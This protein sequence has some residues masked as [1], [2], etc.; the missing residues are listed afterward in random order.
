MN[1]H[2][3]GLLIQKTGTSNK[4]N[5]EFCGV[6]ICGNK[7]ANILTKY[8]SNKYIFK[9]F[10]TDNDYELDEFIINENP[11]V[12]IIN[13]HI[14][15]TSWINFTLIS[16]LKNNY[17]DIKF[18]MIHYDITQKHI[19]NFD[20]M[21]YLKID[22]IISDNKELVIPN[23]LK[24]KIFTV[25]RSIPFLD[26]KEYEDIDVN[27]EEPIIG[28]HGGAFGHKGI[29]KLVL[30]VQEEFDSALIRLHLPPSYYVDPHSIMK[31]IIV[32]NIRKII[33]KKDIK[34]EISSDFLSDYDMI[35]WLQ[36]NSVNCY[37]YDYL[38][39]H[40]LASSP[41][42]AIASKRPI[43]VN[44]STMLKHLHNLEPSIEIEKTTLKEIIKNGTTPLE[45]IYKKYDNRNVFNDYENIIETIL[46]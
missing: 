33:T 32:D 25:N 37:F 1:K 8:N 12:I 5:K 23:N 2:T 34:L 29:E 20:I 36:K 19:D 39:N 17:K 24:N 14:A 44:N 21:R 26:D 9:P 7:L 16:Y 13:Y 10:Y 6:G 45:P 41:D 28:F 15:S 43:A 31:G 3:I 30:L 18:V 42:Y 46:N 38:E 4:K 11:K 27:I 35:K 40:G 22:Y